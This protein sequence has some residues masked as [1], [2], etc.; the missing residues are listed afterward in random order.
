MKKISHLFKPLTLSC[1]RSLSYRNCENQWTCFYMIGTFVKKELKQVFIF[2]FSSWK[3]VSMVSRCTRWVG[4]LTNMSRKVSSSRAESKSSVVRQKDETQNGGN[5]KTRHAKFSKKTNIFYFL[6]CT[7]TYAYHGVSNVRFSENLLRFVFLLPQFWDSSFC[8]I[9]N[10]VMFLWTFKF[11]ITLSILNSNT[12]SS[13]PNLKHDDHFPKV[14]PL[15]VTSVNVNEWVGWFF[16]LVFNLLLY[17]FFLACFELCFYFKLSFLQAEY[18]W[19]GSGYLINFV[20]SLLYYAENK[21]KMVESVV[22]I[23]T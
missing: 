20:I 6:I 10:E 9:A 23:M 15:F 19:P 17:C 2:N 11:G 21:L 18:F 14:L 22:K 5:K 13:I 1:W 7:G 16:L 3:R 8:L 12:N 4:T